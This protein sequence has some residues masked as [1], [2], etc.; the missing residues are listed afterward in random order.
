MHGLSPCSSWSSALAT[1]ALQPLLDFHC[2]K[3]KLAAGAW[4]HPSI[5]LARTCSPPRPCLQQVT[6]LL[7]PLLHPCCRCALFVLEGDNNLLLA[8]T[9]WLAPELHY[10][11]GSGAGGASA[12]SAAAAAAAAGALS[13]ADR[14]SGPGMTVDELL[15]MGAAGAGPP[16]SREIGAPACRATCMRALAPRRPRAAVH[17]RRRR[18]TSAL[19][20]LRSIWGRSPPTHHYPSAMPAC[21]QAAAVPGPRR[22][23]HCRGSRRAW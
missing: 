2:A 14:G 9:R 18:T 13:D 4:D 7:C 17:S 21:L 3:V 10:A 12:A 8:L 5:Q 20:V 1:F 23:L 11:A 16:P 19:T 15:A 22:W 6:V